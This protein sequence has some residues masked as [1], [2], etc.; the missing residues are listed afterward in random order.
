MQLVLP[1]AWFPVGISSL[2]AIAEHVVRSKQNTLVLAGPGAGKT[3]LLAQRASFLLNTGTC[4]APRRML[5]ISFKRDAAANLDERVRQRCG[6]RSARFD[7]HT[8]DAFAKHLV[9]RFRLALPPEWRPLEGYEVMAKSLNV[10]QI[11]EWIESAATLPG[12]DPVNIEQLSDD[13]IKRAFD[14]L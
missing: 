5:A 7:S 2:E 1:D 3:E 9:D 12:H 4:P 11:R 10:D 6:E 8:L 14:R 13:R